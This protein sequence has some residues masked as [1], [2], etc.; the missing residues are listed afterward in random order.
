MAV[1]KEGKAALERP[2]LTDD[3]SPQ[4]GK[5][6]SDRRIS[7]SRLFWGQASRRT[8]PAADG[9]SLVAFLADQI[10][11]WRQ[12]SAYCDTALRIVRTCR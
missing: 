5:L 4:G 11:Q 3:K 2:L 8:F 6:L 12:V 7:F 1:S 10:Q 9:R